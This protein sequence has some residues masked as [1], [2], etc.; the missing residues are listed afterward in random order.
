MMLLCTRS[1]GC[2]GMAVDHSASATM[3]GACGAQ[4]K[5]RKAKGAGMSGKAWA[6]W[7]YRRRGP[8]SKLQSRWQ[9]RIGRPG[10]GVIEH[11]PAW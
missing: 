4:S 6:K 11:T 8:G 3:C 2:P 7:Q 1:Q 5:T 10:I 9:G